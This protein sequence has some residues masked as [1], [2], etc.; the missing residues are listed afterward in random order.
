M[1]N[2]QR[3]ACY[4]RHLALHMLITQYDITSPMHTPVGF[5]SGLAKK[6]QFVSFWDKTLEMDRACHI[7]STGSGQLQLN[8][9]DLSLVSPF[10]HQVVPYNGCLYL[11]FRRTM[12]Q[13]CPSTS[14]L[15]A[16]LTLK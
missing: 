7:V 16:L 11:Y 3:N 5:V 13:V 8:P 14:T 2:T 10:L 12:Y 9:K 4:V 1:N 6:D 15:K